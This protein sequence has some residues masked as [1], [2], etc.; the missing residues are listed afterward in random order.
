MF[1]KY[2]SLK[3]VNPVLFVTALVQAVTGLALALKGTEFFTVIHVYNAF[4]LSFM[5]AVHL[6]LN[7]GWV[8]SFLFSRRS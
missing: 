6:A 4:L 7:W 5:I 2:F 3:W 1:A 8:K